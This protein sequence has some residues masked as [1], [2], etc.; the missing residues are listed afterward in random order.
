MNPLSIKNLDFL[1]LAG[2]HNG[3]DLDRYFNNKEDKEVRR[4]D[5]KL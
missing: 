5:T 2:K 4:P 1:Q 3:D